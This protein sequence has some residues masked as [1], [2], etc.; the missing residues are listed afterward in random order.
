V[1][2][3]DEA[4]L[5]LSTG[6]ADVDALVARRVA[7]EPLE[8]V[9]GWASFC[10]RRVLVDPGVFVPRRRTEF[11][12]ESARALVAPGSLAVDLCCGTG[13]VGAVL[14]DAG[15]TV[16][17]VDVDPV[18]VACAR[19]NVRTVHLGDLFS[20]L[21]AQLRGAVDVIAC[22][23][24]YVPTEKIA[25]MPPEAREW[26]ARVALDGGADG[27][28]VQRR[29]VA[30]APR[31]LRPGGHLL[32][33]TSGAQAPHTAALFEQAGLTA[34]VRSDEERAGTLVAGNKS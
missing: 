9:L 27:L 18:A 34:T 8:Y 4:E 21:P 12:A 30:E 32:V 26:E 29:V 11:L 6:A 20:A 3:E 28:D 17:A 13:A 2:A 16:H 15:A 33:E 23:A 10:G 19:R 22:N 5:L 1:F 25:L 7:G 24:P 14:A 31:W